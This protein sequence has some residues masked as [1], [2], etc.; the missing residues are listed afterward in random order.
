MAMKVSRE[1]FLGV[2]APLKP[3]FDNVAA[4]MALDFEAEVFLRLKKLGLKRKDL[5][6]RLGVSPAAVSKLLA[7]NSNMTL[8]TMAKVAVA[9]GCEVS[10]IRLTEIGDVDY[11]G[12]DDENDTDTVLVPREK[13]VVE[14]FDGA[15]STG[16]LVSRS[17]S[18][19]FGVK[20]VP[21]LSLGRIAA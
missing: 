16:A 7:E 10:S 17:T 13:P 18:A 15:F 14:P 21:V 20:E 19:S 12:L 8:K 2:D 6:E 9:L 5:A 4:K 1:E 11:A 3:S